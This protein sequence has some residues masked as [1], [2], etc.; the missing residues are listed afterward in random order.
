MSGRRII[1]LTLFTETI[2][3]ERYCNEMLCS[4]VDKL[5]E[6]EKLTVY[7]RQN[8]ATAQTANFT[9]NFY[10]YHLPIRR[11]FQKKLAF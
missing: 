9:L 2:A 7:F 6:V 10:K 1:R 4:F 11:H 5:S 3:A 8:D